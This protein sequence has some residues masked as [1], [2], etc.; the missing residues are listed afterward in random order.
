MSD[1]IIGLSLVLPVVL[2]I[3][4]LNYSRKSKKKKFNRQLADYIQQITT[5]YHLNPG[6]QQQ[7][8]FQSV[9]IDDDRGKLIVIDHKHDF[10]HKAYVLNDIIN[11]SMSYLTNTFIG[12][13]NEKPETFIAHIGVKINFESRHDDVVLILYDHIEHSIY[14]REQY[15][16]QAI[17]LHEIIKSKT[18]YR[19]HDAPMSA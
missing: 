13:K 19:K 12:E 17:E 7:L 11:S 2:V 3:W 5:Q 9:L 15:E 18:A 16:K 6:F 4:L 8:T 14:Q 10:K 1:L